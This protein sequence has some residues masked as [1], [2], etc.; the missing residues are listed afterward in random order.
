MCAQFILNVGSYQQFLVWLPVCTNS[1]VTVEKN[2]CGGNG[3]ADLSN[4]TLFR[5]SFAFLHQWCS[6]REYLRTE[7][8]INKKCTCLVKVSA[9]TSVFKPLFVIN[10]VLPESKRIFL[11]R[12]NCS[13]TGVLCAKQTCSDDKQPSHDSQGSSSCSAPNQVIDGVDVLNRLKICQI[14]GL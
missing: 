7:A 3:Q 5:N 10:H 12:E 2:L 6:S 9:L 1:I 8:N 14:S 11:E 13:G 4:L